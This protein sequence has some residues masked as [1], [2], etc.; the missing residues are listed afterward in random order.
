[1]ALSEVAAEGQPA[2]PVHAALAAVAA[3]LMLRLEEIP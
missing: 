1:V 2:R 3:E